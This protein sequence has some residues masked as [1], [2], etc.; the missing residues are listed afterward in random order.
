M[1]MD[2][3][4][5]RDPFPD[6][7]Q[8]PPLEIVEQGRVW[9]VKTYHGND[10]SGEIFTTHDSQIDAVRSTKTKMEAD[11]HP[12]ALR[13][14]SARS[15]GNLYW[16]PLFKRL[17]V[18]YDEL[19]D[20]WTIVP[21]EGTCAIDS[22]RHRDDA[23]ER[24]KEVQ[25]T[26]NFK[27]LRVYDE[28]DS[29]FDEREHRFLRRGITRSGVRFDPSALDR[30]SDTAGDPTEGDGTADADEEEE[31]YVSP[32]SPGQL[33]ASI[34][35]VTKVEFID[36]DGVLNRYATPWGDGTRAEIVAVSQKYADNQQVRAAFETWLPR[37]QAVDDNPTVATIYESGSEPV[38]WVAYQVGDSTLAE[39]GTDLPVDRR[40]SLLNQV[41]TALDAVATASGEPACAGSPHWIYVHTAGSEER[42]AVSQF[43]IEWDVQYAVGEDTP[44]LF[45]AP[46]QIDGRLTATTAVYHVGAIAY[47]LLCESPPTAADIDRAVIK[48]GDIPPARPVSGVPDSAG[49]VIDRALRPTPTERYDSVKAFRRALHRAV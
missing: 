41:C 13:W 49:T 6:L 8:R 33:G 18:R 7:P 2:A 32:A 44:T 10:K 43:G 45:T 47:S 48:S 38:P 12:C 19:L 3:S 21:S 16:N 40:L 20:T 22:R 23:C 29:Q 36:T 1:D 4:S 42:A 11:A 37:W 27:H 35:D 17:E 14:D 31:D 39:V 15:V 28:S 5:E 9:L 24:A 26:Y 34:P 25:Y 30:P 46:E